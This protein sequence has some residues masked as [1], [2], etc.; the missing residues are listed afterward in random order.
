MWMRTSPRQCS[1]PMALPYHVHIWHLPPRI[2]PLSLI[3]KPEMAIKDPFP[4]CNLLIVSKLYQ[5]AELFCL[6][7]FHLCH[8]CFNLKHF[9]SS[10]DFFQSSCWD[11][12]KISMTRCAPGIRR[13]SGTPQMADALVLSTCDIH[14][15]GSL[16]QKLASPGNVTITKSY[17]L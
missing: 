1:R 10:T 4:F 9:G 15:M 17:I 3:C 13:V 5:W 8:W 12:C 11:G 14:I 7:C 16:H 2:S 6:P